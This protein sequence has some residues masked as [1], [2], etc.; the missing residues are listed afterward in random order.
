M[1]DQDS[2]TTDP[3]AAPVSCTR[4]LTAADTMALS[5]ERSTTEAKGNP[6][7]SPPQPVCAIPLVP[8]PSAP[9]FREADQAP[10]PTD[11]VIA[12]QHFLI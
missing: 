8:I 3:S 12:L 11:L 4:T 1:G 10:P 2:G 5:P 6:L 7:P 9:P